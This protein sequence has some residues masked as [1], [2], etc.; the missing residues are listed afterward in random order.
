MRMRR[1]ITCFI[2]VCVIVA[3]MALPASAK[4]VLGVSANGYGTLTGKTTQSDVVLTSVTSVT[5]NPDNAYL[6]IKVETQTLTGTKVNGRTATSSRGVTS[7]QDTMRMTVA[8]EAPLPVSGF[9]TY[10]VYGGTIYESAAYYTTFII[11]NSV[12]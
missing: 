8:Y 2:L 1:N 10:E 11:D 3:A 4:L 6:R 5:S 9:A 12:F 7:F